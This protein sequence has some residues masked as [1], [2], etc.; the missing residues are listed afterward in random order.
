MLEDGICLQILKE[1]S[2]FN[3]VMKTL[4]LRKFQLRLLSYA[5]CAMQM[6]QP[7]PEAAS[8]ADLCILV[9]DWDEIK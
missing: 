9:L 3:L 1:K 6:M 5:E 2:S 7:Y 8:W 4:L